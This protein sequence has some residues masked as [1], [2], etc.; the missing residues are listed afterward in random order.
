MDKPRGPALA[1]RESQRS[2][3]V[4]VLIVDDSALVRQVMTSILAG[5]PGI[6]VMG[7]VPDPYF[8]AQ[9]IAEEVPDVI[10]LDI[11]MPRMDGLTFLDKIMSQHP[12]PVVICSS[13]AGPGCE[14]T[15]RAFELGAVEVIAKPRIDT[16][17]FLEEARIRICDIV[18][19]AA[20]VRCRPRP[21][22]SIRPKLSADVMLPRPTRAQALQTT[23]RVV[24]VGAST[25]GT[26][27]L[28]VFLEALPH[29]GPGI[30]IVQHMPEKFTASFVKRLDRLCRVTVKEAEDGDPMMRG[31][32]LIAPG[33]RHLLLKRSGARYYVEVRDGPL[34]SRHRP[35]VDV[36]FRSAARCAGANVVAVIM[37]G[38]GDD[39]ASGMLEL[40][41]AGAQ[42]IAQDE[43]T[44]V[45]FGMPH[46]AI[47]RGG[48]DVVLPLER[49]AAEVLRRC[50]M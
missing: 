37:T 34:V 2:G 11:E 33:N 7:A 21:S 26:E 20:R 35:S 29:D 27:A 40:K 13:L 17:T 6:S 10:I 38:M 9:R 50:A 15:F 23:D 49:I 47:A 32:V 22:L 31:H 46:E 41:E 1:G 8:A 39:G 30:A 3:P 16:S 42:T 14:A 4:R 44:S 43:A 28:R 45:V 24:V 5:D 19:A 12:I 18:K 48:V 25:G 36:L